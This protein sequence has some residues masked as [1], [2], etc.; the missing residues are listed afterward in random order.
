MKISIPPYVPQLNP[1][2]PG[3]WVHHLIGVTM[4]RSRSS[5]PYHAVLGRRT[6]TQECHHNMPIIN[7]GRTCFGGNS[8]VHYFRGVTRL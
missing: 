2:K 3:S 4:H 8:Q 5:A 1:H 6:P 7:Q